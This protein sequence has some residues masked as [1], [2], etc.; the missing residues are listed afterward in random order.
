MTQR[1]PAVRNRALTGST[2]LRP[3][4]DR[5]CRLPQEDR[6]RRVRR[7]AKL[8]QG[9]ADPPVRRRDLGGTAAPEG[10]GEGDAVAAGVERFQRQRTLGQREARSRVVGDKAQ[11]GQ[12]QQTA[13]MA[14]A[15]LV[16]LDP[17]V[18]GLRTWRRSGS[19]SPRHSATASASRA[20]VRSM[21]PSARAWT[22]RLSRVSR[23]HRST[24]RNPD[25]RSRIVS[26][27]QRRW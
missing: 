6:R 4:T 10:S 22:A 9:R 8:P 14:D 3:G 25:G 5:A 1:C 15:N 13:D 18:P 20:A 26:P 21:S 24:E 12:R 23:V 16:D 7:D 19:G 2:A 27:S 11:F 17:D